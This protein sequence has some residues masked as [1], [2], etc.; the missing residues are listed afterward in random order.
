M[1]PRGKWS[2]GGKIVRILGRI[3]VSV[4]QALFRKPSGGVLEKDSASA[5]NSTELAR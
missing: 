4:P 5:R 1:A 2:P 3:G